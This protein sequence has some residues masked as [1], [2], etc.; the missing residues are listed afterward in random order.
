MLGYNEVIKVVSP[1]LKEEN[2]KGKQEGSLFLGL[3]WLF[4]NQYRKHSN[5]LE[6]FQ[7]TN[8][9]NLSDLGGNVRNLGKFIWVNSMNT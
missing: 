2:K 5:N 6:Y 9:K 3:I 4:K 1:P 7:K 8:I